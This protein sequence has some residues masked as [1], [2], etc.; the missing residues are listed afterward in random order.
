[1]TAELPA[2]A[3]R[4]KKVPKKAA[5]GKATNILAKPPPVQHPLSQEAQVKRAEKL[6]KKIGDK[7][8]VSFITGTKCADQ[9]MSY[10]STGH[11][12]L[13]DAISGDHDDDQEIIEGTGRGLPKGRIVE[14]YGKEASCKTSLALS[15][16]AQAQRQGEIAAFIDV[17]HALNAEFA[18][19]VFGV[20]MPALLWSQPDDGEEA[21]AVLDALVDSGEVGV[22]V[23][24]S[25]AALVSRNEAGGGKALG[26]QARL[27]SA[28]CRKLTAKLKSGTG[29]CVIFLNQIRNKI[30]VLYGDPETTCGGLALLFY[31]SV[32]IK[33]RKKKEVKKTSKRTKGQ[34][35]V[36]AV[37][38]C[39]RVTKN[40]VAPMGGYSEFTLNFKKG[41]T[42]PKQKDDDVDDGSD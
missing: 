24:D 31:S 34:P 25:V 32:R 14:I 30:G 40:K 7:L 23:L 41:I 9:A 21:L 33:M 8:R 20:D 16:V 26:E 36:V 18:R 19:K 13:D 17:E 12:A 39:M 29:P 5:G 1:M 6:A 38:M 11:Q 27:M 22:I 15:V 4:K 3:P 10:L 35:K 37:H 42:F 2:A 28:T